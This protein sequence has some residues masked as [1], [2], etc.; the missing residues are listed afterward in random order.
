MA[1]TIMEA[2]V[3]LGTSSG[4]L[5]LC[6]HLMKEQTLIKYNACVLSMQSSG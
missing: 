3:V 1:C 5:I 2:H 4:H 6:D